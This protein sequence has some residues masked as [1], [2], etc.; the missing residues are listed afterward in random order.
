MNFL[1]KLEQKDLYIA[2]DPI[3]S[4]GPNAPRH[5]DDDLHKE[6]GSKLC[7][8]ILEKICKGNL[9]VTVEMPIDAQQTFVKV[10]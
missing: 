5:E 1:F 3:I 9:E 8:L 4:S 6:R 7:C 2:E 10:T